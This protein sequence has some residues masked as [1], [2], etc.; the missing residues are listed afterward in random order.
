MANNITLA[1]NYTDLLDE[2]FKNASVTA[3]LSG[4]ARFTRQG[5]N[6]STIYYPAIETTGLGD[7]SRTGGYPDGGVSVTWKSASFNYDRGTRIMVDVMDDQETFNIA[8][9]R[10]GAELI[11]TKVAPEADAFTFA[12]LAALSGVTTAA[13]AAIA[14]ADAFLAALQAA[15][16]ALDDAEVPALEMEEEKIEVTHH[17]STAREYIPSGLAD[18][19][20]YE[21]EMETDRANTVHKQI[22]EL[23]TSKEVVPWKL[24]YPDGLTYQFEASVLKIT[25]ADAD[26]QSPDVIID[27]VG[28]AIS[29]EIQDIS[30]EVLGG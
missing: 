19:G 22:L 23:R 3:G 14:G 28:L 27:T 10:A 21:F 13:A 1:S 25:R 26:P 9:G 17:G 18:P 5:A 12:T 16:D 2:V 29:G 24:I 15:E 11:R 30:D 7:Y 6:A 4:D 8:A 20:D